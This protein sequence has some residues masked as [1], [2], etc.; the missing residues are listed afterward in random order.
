MQKGLQKTLIFLSLLGVV[1]FNSLLINFNAMPAHAQAPN[2]KGYLPR[3]AD[4]M[5]ETMQVIIPSFGLRDT[6]TIGPWRTMR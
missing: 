3:L 1:A 4:L 6:Q 5:N 2:S